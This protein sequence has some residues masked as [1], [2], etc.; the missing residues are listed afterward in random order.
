MVR[1]ILSHLVAVLLC[2]RPGVAQTT[3]DAPSETI[4][5][6]VLES[7]LKQLEENTQLEEDARAKARL[8]YEQAQRELEKIGS[9]QEAI[10]QFEQQAAAAKDNLE[11]AKSRRSEASKPRAEVRVVTGAKLTELEQE[12]T[13]RETLLKEKTEN[14]A[15]LDA[16][17]KR[18]A[19][20][21]EEISKSL[22][23]TQQEVAEIEKTRT[24]PSDDS[25]VPMARRTA[26]LV[27]NELLS[28]TL[29]LLEK[30]RAAYE[31]T[32]ELLQVERDIAAAEFAVAET[33]S[34]RWRELVNE[35]RT[36]EANEQARE[37]HRAWLRAT[38]PLAALAH[39]IELLTEQRKKLARDIEAAS[40]DLEASRKVLAKVSTEFE[41]AKE[42]VNVAGLS[43]RSGEILRG[44]RASLPDLRKFRRSTKSR[45]STLQDAHF[46]EYGYQDRRLELANLE[47]SANVLAGN[48]DGETTDATIAE[49]RELLQLKKDYLDGLIGD[50]EAYA[51][52]LLQLD[53]I[54]RQLIAVTQQ[55]AGYIDERVLWIR[56]TFILN[57]RD[58]LPALDA[59]AWLT[60]RNNWAAV[61][62]ELFPKSR[63]QA[64]V[65]SLC[66]LAY[67]I[68]VY[69]QRPVRRTLTEISKSVA[70]RGF[71][72][73]VPTVRAVFLTA[74]ASMVWPSIAAYFSWLLSSSL[75][76][77]VRALGTALLWTAYVWLPL[78]FV[79]Q[80]CRRN[81]LAESHFQ[82]P[83][84]LLRIIRKR[85]QSLLVVGLPLLLLS[86][87]LEFQTTE[88][89]WGSSLGRV[90]FI[91][92]LFVS[93]FCLQRLLFAKGGVVQQMLLT[94]TLPRMLHRT[95]SILCAVAPLVLAILAAVGYYDT[96]QTLA[97]RLFQTAYVV[98]VLML[99]HALLGRWVLMRRRR[100]TIEQA[101]QRRTA[102]S[103]SPASYDPAS[104]AAT[105]EV[106]KEVDLGSVSKQTVK[107]L[108]TF[109]IL[110]GALCGW[111][112]W[113]DVVP[114]LS[115]LKNYP[116]WQSI[117]EV[118]L[119]DI[120]LASVIVAVTYVA[121][122][123]VPGVL[124]L[125]LLNYLPVDAGARFATT[126]VCRYAITAGGLTLAGQRLGITWD[127][128][129]WLIAAMGIGLGFGLQEIFANFISGII[130]L[131]ERPI[132]VGD[133]ITLGDTTG[134]VTRIR[135]RA[136][137]VTDWNR[138][139]YVVPN[140]D[141][142]TG[143][144]LNWTLTD[145][146]NRIV[147][148][149][150]VAYG[151]DTER[152]RSLL[153]KVAQ[154]H[155]LILDDPKPIATFEGFGDST[156]NLVL[157]CYL[158]DLQHR[159]PTI[160]ELHFAIDR[161]FRN[162]GIEIAFPQQ[163]I[164]IRTIQQPLTTLEGRVP[165][166]SPYN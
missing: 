79:R 108:R 138:K 33:E 102:E 117:Q 3:A 107:L 23:D 118:T 50:Y 17:P 36:Q 87:T 5:K 25:A 135:M 65:L 8:H 127:S 29:S 110:A 100:L 69:L 129:Q 68:L 22:T 1:L 144:L 113:D 67:G 11:K 53:D 131:F 112:I 60:S 46:D 6:E 75:S 40:G 27:R 14:L 39:E 2:C 37:A 92:F 89:L 120:L 42:K 13:K 35:R 141:L 96:S 130:L 145:Q 94:T 77:F 154:V 78:E 139:E 150:G 45:Q 51:K 133:I 59:S 54:E 148:P 64:V 91:G 9:S 105:Q 90:A 10:Q 63:F 124:E 30:E 70:R 111:L 126:T 71:S 19:S 143:R 158:P 73:F 55:Y 123:N 81:G 74:V 72:K 137:T 41:R 147:I 34:K 165:D 122:R 66:V 152:A 146:T 161:E 128:I 57:H 56:S 98:F 119:A 116:V 32:T 18:R 121:T 44:E 149:V 82:W 24:A 80:V 153:L 99:V 58:I 76:D 159:L 31:A 109:V 104:I 83:S 166:E 47:E 16:E 162:A 28:V 163:D 7:R 156:L 86:L 61:G 49:V 43:H 48:L 132:R 106:S 38:P 155:P 26:A 114:A 97:I 125:T 142:V 115:I 12:L 140:K 93:S 15:K 157:R 62:Q 136:T 20:R 151:S 95:W 84:S 85:V 88:P 4:S 164:H 21:L 134:V 103:E 101:R 52:T 160:S